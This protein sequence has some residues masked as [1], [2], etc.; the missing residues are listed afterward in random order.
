MTLSFHLGPERHYD[1]ASAGSV[2]KLTLGP[3]IQK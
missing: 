1:C 2:A 3:A